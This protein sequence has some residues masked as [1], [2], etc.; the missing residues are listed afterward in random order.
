MRE[1]AFYIYHF[2][3]G[4]SL[5]TYHFIGRLVATWVLMFPLLIYHMLLVLKERSLESVFALLASFLT[6]FVWQMFLIGIAACQSKKNVLEDYLLQFPDSIYEYHTLA[7]SVDEKVLDA[8]QEFIGIGTAVDGSQLEC[9]IYSVHPLDIDSSRDKDLTSYPTPTGI[10]S[11]GSFIFTR[12]RLDSP[13]KFS[14]YHELGHQ[15]FDN[16]LEHHI[17]GSDYYPYLLSLIWIAP[18]IILG[19]I[20]LL[21]I[22]SLSL[23]LILIIVES[24]YRQKKSKLREEMRAD[25]FAIRFLTQEER[26]ALLNVLE[27]YPDFYKDKAMSEDE[28]LERRRTLITSLYTLYFNDES[29]DKVYA[30]HWAAKDFFWFSSKTRVVFLLLLSGL[31]LFSHDVTLSILIVYVFILACLYA[32]VRQ[33]KKQHDILF[34]EILDW[35]KETNTKNLVRKIW[36]SMNEPRFSETED[37]P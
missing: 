28:H 4:L 13:S 17:K 12:N 5:F 14:L 11:L 30:I 3:R 10:R 7:E 9:Y 25:A 32:Y 16:S 35:I 37:I 6:V 36:K 18:N 21:L 2:F 26:R 31:V 1:I 23:V 29:F 34:K 27:K 15:T 33:L 22:A 8:M 24:H 20:S 19:T